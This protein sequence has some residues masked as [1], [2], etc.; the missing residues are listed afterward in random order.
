MIVHALVGSSCCTFGL[1]VGMT[2]AVVFVVATSARA[3]AADDYDELLNILVVDFDIKPLVAR[4]IIEKGLNAWSRWRY[5][6]RPLLWRIGREWPEYSNVIKEEFRA[7]YER[8]LPETAQPDQEESLD[9]SDSLD[10][11]ETTSDEIEI[12]ADSMPTSDGTG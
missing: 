3:D 5:K 9:Y 1:V 10:D 6:T 7:I 4:R 11:S 12:P 8:G 2:L